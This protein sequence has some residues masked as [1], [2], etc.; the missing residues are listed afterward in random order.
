[1]DDNGEV[2]I[3]HVDDD[4][5]FIEMDD[6]GVREKGFVYKKRRYRNKT[7]LKGLGKI[8]EDIRDYDIASEDLSEVMEA[9]TLLT[10]VYADNTTRIKPANLQQMKE[11]FGGFFS[12]LNKMGIS[13]LVV[14]HNPISKIGSRFELEKLRFFNRELDRQKLT[15]LNADG[16]MS[17]G[18]Q[19]PFGAG[20]GIDRI[21]SIRSKIQG[22]LNRKL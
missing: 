6:K 13:T 7:I 11:K 16:E 21:D 1:V 9:F 17:S 10:A 19:K 20:L 3:G 14:G 2:S 22:I 8:A 12:I 18:Y 15:I 5:V 4:G